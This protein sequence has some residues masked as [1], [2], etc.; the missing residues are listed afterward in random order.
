MILLISLL[1]TC[2]IFIFFEYKNSKIP[3]QK[4]H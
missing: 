2:G 1:I 3:K 4:E